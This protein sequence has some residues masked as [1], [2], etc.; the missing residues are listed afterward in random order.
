MQTFH[1]RAARWLP[2]V[3]AAALLFGALL[4]AQTLG[5]PAPTSG[6]CTTTA[7]GAVVCS[8]S[9]GTA[10]APSATTDTTNAANIATGTLNSAR[11]PVIPVA[12]LQPLVMDTA[13]LLGLYRFDETAGNLIDYSG[14]GNIGVVGTAP[15]R[16]GV[17]YQF[18]ST[19]QG[20]DWPAALNAT[21]TY[22]LVITTQTTAGGQSA[23]GA[24][25]LATILSSTAT[26]AAG[27]LINM[28]NPVYGP[29]APDSALPGTYSLSY[30]AANSYTSQVFTGDVIT[31]THVVALSCP[32]SGAGTF[33]LDGLP[34]TNQSGSAACSNVQTTGNFRLGQPS[35]ASGLF[36]QGT[37]YWAAAFYST[38]DAA[39]IV[40]KRSM[41]LRQYAQGKGAP[42]AGQP[43]LPSMYAKL[44]GIGDSILCGYGISDGRCTT[45]G[46]G[47][48]P[49]AYLSLTPALLNNT[50][51]A[52]NYGVPGA[53]VQDNLASS[54]VLVDPQATSNF[55]QNFAV[56]ASGTNN[57]NSALSYSGT[58][59]MQLAWA[60]SRAQA[61]LRPVL[62]GL[63]SR[64][65]SVG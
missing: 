28:K 46:G 59:G 41:A 3:F 47:T 34:L 60:N 54:P 20:L 11:L 23:Y 9:N 31:G 32:A 58:W 57:F 37:S 44:I 7:A 65:A 63:T 35:G 2:F 22:Y 49:S 55:G 50:Y 25:N 10:F 13:G 6:D 43:Q 36:P 26:T 4:E 52:L 21:N 29:F 42:F 14:N 16:N 38:S 1:V 45:G 51:T 5:V 12:N 64:Y 15:V 61:G 19:A 48:S 33:Y 56:L 40:A 53:Y 27:L 18:T 39:P 24:T 62:V 30:G 8:K 17:S